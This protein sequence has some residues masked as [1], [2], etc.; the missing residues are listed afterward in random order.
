[1]QLRSSEQQVGRVFRSY[2]LKIYGYM[3]GGLLLTGLVSFFTASSPTMVKA[4]FG[5]PLQYVVMF[6]PLIFVMVISFG[7]N[8]LRAQTAQILFWMFA[9]VMGL[10]LSSI[11]LAYTGLSV[12]RTFLVCSSM[13]LVM[14]IYGYVT[15]TDLS[16]FGNILL[17]A[18][19]GIIIASVVNIFLK[20][21]GLEF[22]VSILGVIIF[23][24]LTAWDTQKIKL[25]Y[26]VS[27]D[28]EVSSKKSIIGA[29]SLYL[30][31]INLFL[32]LLRLMGNNRN[33]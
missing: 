28:Y 20:S 5:T 14:C 12:A 15:Q 22:A 8:K 2:M 16:R 19:I 18:L 6:A 21:T 27:D 11:F 25:S 17:M 33:N 3:T 30:D 29:L 24:G 1:M 32:M 7:I 31:F 13:F 23:A 4:I 9:L 10:S 26:D